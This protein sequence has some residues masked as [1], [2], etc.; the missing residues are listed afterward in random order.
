MV[1][2]IWWMD[3][4]LEWEIHS[5]LKFYGRVKKASKRNFQLIFQEDIN[6]E[7]GE[8]KWD[9][10]TGSESTCMFW[11]SISGPLFCGLCWS[12]FLNPGFCYCAYNIHEETIVC[13]QLF[14]GNR[15]FLIHEIKFVHPIRVLIVE[16]SIW[17][18]INT[19]SYSKMSILNFASNKFFDDDDYAL[20]A[21]T[22][23]RLA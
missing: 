3:V 1:D 12:P 23:S 8:W 9:S 6:D 10:V 13:L 22:K 7:K 20:S 18:D 4:R 16:S 19:I 17:G 14:V 11:Q 2:G 15:T 5:R 21:V